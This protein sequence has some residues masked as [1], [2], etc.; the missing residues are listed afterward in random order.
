MEMSVNILKKVLVKLGRRPGLETLL[1]SKAG[2]SKIMRPH[3][4]AGK[5]KSHLRRKPG[6]TPAAWR[7]ELKTSEEHGAQRQEE[8]GHSGMRSHQSKLR[9]V[10]LLARMMQACP[11]DSDGKTPWA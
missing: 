5:M 9:G 2:C 1:D 7:F 6:Q 11:T 10:L 8:G 4:K 3:G